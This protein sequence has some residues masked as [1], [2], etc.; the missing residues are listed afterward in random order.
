MQIETY[1]LKSYCLQ[2]LNPVDEK[3]DE[4][5]VLHCRLVIRLDLK[6][7][8]PFGSTSNPLQTAVARNRASAI[9]DQNY[10][11]SGKLQQVGR[12]NF[13]VLHHLTL[14]P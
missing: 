10:L 8:I 5:Y 14:I 1:A 7:Q 11:L 13:A 2:D 9:D 3:S 12:I 4:K 6:T